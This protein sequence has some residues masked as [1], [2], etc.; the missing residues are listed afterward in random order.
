MGVQIFHFG[1]G[2]GYD[3]VDI[4]R[5]ECQRDKHSSEHRKET[6]T[7]PE[8]LVLKKAVVYL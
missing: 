3:D 6:L 8:I 7:D 5:D 1:G 4:D 2:C